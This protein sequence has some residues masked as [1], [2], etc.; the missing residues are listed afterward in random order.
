MVF[1]EGVLGYLPDNEEEFRWRYG[2]DAESCPDHLEQEEWQRFKEFERYADL[3]LTFAQRLTSPDPEAVEQEVQRLVGEAYELER[4]PWASDDEDDQWFRVSEDGEWTEIGPT[5]EVTAWEFIRELVNYR[6]SEQELERATAMTDRVR[7]LLGLLIAVEDG[8][9]RAYLG[10][11]AQCYLLGLE[12]EGLVMCR[13]VLEAACENVTLARR[14][15]NARQ[16]TNDP[17][18]CDMLKYLRHDRRVLGPGIF[19]TAMAIKDR[20]N[21]AVHKKPAEEG[22]RTTLEQLG[23]VLEALPAGTENGGPV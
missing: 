20:G 1:S 19:K 6:L 3:L 17:S 12:T 9:T 23:K 11:V 15:S 7:E 4:S 5:Y 13:S 14:V 16:T 22:L 8:R 21:L 18:L 10:R 2:L